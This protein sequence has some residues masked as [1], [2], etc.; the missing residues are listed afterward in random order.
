MIKPLQ[1]FKILFCNLL[2]LITMN[3]SMAQEI[4]INEIHYDNTGADTN[5]GVE[6]VGNAGTDLA[7]WSLVTYNGS[8]GSQYNSIAMVGTIIDQQN[9]YGTVFFPI[10]GLQNGSP[11]GIALVNLEGTVIQF[12]SYEGT[13]VAIGG[14]ADG[15]ESVDIGVGQA[16]S[17]PEGYSLQLIGEGFDYSDFEWTEASLNTYN[18]INSGQRFG[19]GGTNPD[20]D[21]EPKEVTIAAAKELPL[22]AEVIVNG[23][24][25]VADQLGGPAFIQ[26]STGGIALFDYQVHSDSI[27]EI[28]DSLRI[29][30]SIGA[31]NQQV[32]LVDVT[33]LTA[34]G[35]ADSPIIPE[36]VSIAEIDSLEGQLVTIPGVHFIENEGLL[37]PESNYLIRDASGETQL[38]IDGDVNSLVGREIPEDTLSVTGVLG[39][40]RG[41]LQILPRFIED[42]PGTEEYL[43]VGTDIP[44][45][46]TL[47]VMT[48]NMEFFG[49]TQ[50]NFGPANI[51][52]QLENA[53]KLLDSIDA[54]VVAVQ[55]V[56]DTNF[57][58]RLVEM[59]PGYATICSDR[60]SYSF[61][62]P[63]PE[64]P[65][66]Q[67]CFIYNTAVIK[68]KGSK[69]LFENMYDAARNGILTPLHDYPTGKSSS[70][71]S[72]G[73]LP[74]LVTADA[75]INGNTQTIRFINIH[76]KSGSGSEDIERKRFDVQALKDTLD[77]YYSNDNIVLL[78][79]YNDD[80]DESIG[81]GISPYASFVGDSDYHLVTA[82]LSEEGLR[83]YIFNDNMIDHI[84]ISDE[85]NEEY[86]SG[87]ET[88]FIPFSFIENYANTTS[89]H[90]PVLTRFEFDA[91]LVVSAGSDALVYA[92]YEPLGC[93]TLQAGEVSGGTAPFVFSW[94]NGDFGPSIEVCPT[95]TQN[96]ILTVTDANGGS[97]SD[98]VKVCVID[99]SCSDKP[100]S[101]KVQTCMNPS[102]KS[103]RERTFCVPKI[104]VKRLLARGASLGSCN[105]S[106]NNQFNEKQ[107]DYLSG[108]WRE[109]NVYPN[110]VFNNINIDFDAQVNGKIELI[111]FDF[112]GNQVFSKKMLVE[113][114]HLEVD[115]TKLQLK[116]QICYLKVNYES[117][118]KMI[119]IYKK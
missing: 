31:F 58:N 9:G 88:L 52:L 94:S 78:G 107:N 57:L 8:N 82:S 113:N 112:M 26:D 103:G 92:G 18:D 100:G 7:G 81:G 20:P 40:F 45:S 10:E 73:R 80:V 15:S 72:S 102:G 104:A 3:C 30:A 118:Q 46:T 25:I 97:A 33:E 44:V 99:I 2:V 105:E 71:W 6:I 60:Y 53:F 35:K 11:D 27:F 4:F 114:G 21:P 93:T 84:T 101:Q 32:Q 108:L 116:D 76:A 65:P 14:P 29:T 1:I 42:L 64:F 79:D 69:V 87:T 54:D 115:I 85:L 109:F 61:D 74:F 36:I 86:I 110:P 23:I 67:I 28:G 37:F 47:D 63:D 50:D 66:Q 90:L 41:E 119:R 16:S 55:E 22:G 5:E 17:T 51:D 96:Y 56:S 98:S 59:L 91:P 43:P 12:L 75:T 95:E 34:F 70:F 38:R 48:W 19:E 83:S 49:A 39:S 106:C 24:L 13:L 117:G 68:I 89:D 111:L 77:Q 62:G